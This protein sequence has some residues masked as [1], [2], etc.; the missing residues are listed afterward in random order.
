MDSKEFVDFFKKNH[1]EIFGS[2]RLL[3]SYFV[4][5]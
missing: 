4:S 5:R 2:V 3:L 1:G